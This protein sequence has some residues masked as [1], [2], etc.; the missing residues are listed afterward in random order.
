MPVEAV[1]QVRVKLLP[2]STVPEALLLI[3]GAWGTTAQNKSKAA[4]Q[5]HSLFPAIN[6]HVPL[7]NDF[8]FQILVSIQPFR[9][10]AKPAGFLQMSTAQQLCRIIVQAFQKTKANQMQKPNKQSQN[11]S[12]QVQS[13]VSLLFSWKAGSLTP[14]TQQVQRVFMSTKVHLVAD[15][16]PSLKYFTSQSQFTRTPPTA[17]INL[18][19]SPDSVTALL[20]TSD[21]TPL[22]VTLHV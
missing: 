10:Y 6:V 9:Y 22:K 20:L 11:N 21:V 7:S 3:V 17:S 2:S 19:S 5:P 1:W 14:M 16:A 4:S 8:S 12:K 15:R 18:F 13:S